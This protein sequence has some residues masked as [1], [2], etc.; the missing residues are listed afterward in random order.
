MLTTELLPALDGDWV[1]NGTVS[2][3]KVDTE[4]EDEEDNDM[5]ADDGD[6]IDGVDHCED[7]AVADVTAAVAC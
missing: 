3:E 5:G 7:A 6:G 4:A 2:C 1:C